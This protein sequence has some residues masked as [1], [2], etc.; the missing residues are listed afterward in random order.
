M[1]KFNINKFYDTVST[2]KLFISQFLL[3]LFIN[4]VYNKLFKYRE[5][6]RQ[7]L[8]CLGTF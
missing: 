8:V 5:F 7:K 3:L 4:K 6:I 2:C 1:H